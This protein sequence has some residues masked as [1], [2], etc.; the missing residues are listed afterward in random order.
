[1]G[2]FVNGLANKLIELRDLNRM[3]GDEATVQEVAE[4]L[5]EMVLESHIPDLMHQEFR[6][7]TDEEVRSMTGRLAGVISMAARNINAKCSA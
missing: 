7:L 1:M 2:T 6:T 4:V 5:L 3:D